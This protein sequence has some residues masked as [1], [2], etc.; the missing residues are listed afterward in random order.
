MDSGSLCNGMVFGL[1]GW[2]VGCWGAVNWE[3]GREE[4]GIWREGSFCWWWERAVFVSDGG[5]R[6]MCKR[7]AA[8]RCLVWSVSGL[9]VLFGLVHD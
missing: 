1:S 9:A 3:I 8:G 6:D 2:L 4:Q 7:L 5:V